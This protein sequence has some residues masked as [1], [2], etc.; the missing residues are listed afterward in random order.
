MEICMRP[1]EKIIIHN[2]ATPEGRDVKTKEIKRWHIEERGFSDIGYHYIIELDGK[3]KVGRPLWRVGAHCKG[4]N[5]KSIGICY[6]GGM[7]ADMSKP[8]N[9]LNECQE[10]SLVT[11]LTMLQNQFKG[12]TIHGHNEFSKKACPSFDVQE[13]LTKF[14]L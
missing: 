12:A 1:I 14:D 7:E 8:K 5:R 6:V 11:L 2:S 9:T 3:A 10:Q 4:Q 13:W